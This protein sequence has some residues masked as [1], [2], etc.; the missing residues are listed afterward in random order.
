MSNLPL[1]R[2]D[3][4]DERQLRFVDHLCTLI[5]ENL[6]QPEHEEDEEGEIVLGKDG[7][8]K[9]KPRLSMSKMRVE[10]A[11]RAGYNSSEAYAATESFRLL[12]QEKIQQAITNWW[13]THKVPYA[14]A[15]MFRMGNIIMSTGSKDAD[16]IKA[17]ETFM[18]RDKEMAKKAGKLDVQHSNVP[19]SREARM[20]ELTALM[21]FIGVKQQNVVEAAFTE[22]LPAPVAAEVPVYDHHPDQPGRAVAQTIEDYNKFAKAKRGAARP[23][24][25]QRPDRKPRGR[26][27]LPAN[28]M[29][30]GYHHSR[31]L[32]AKALNK[33]CEDI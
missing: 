25:P 26:R 8:P 32:R 20:A 7:R 15:G 31:K 16:A 12:Q 13:A 30:P 33:L 2:G 21:Q 1:R 23:L 11:M 24:K 14:L 27:P 17:T 28:E 19:M 18:D 10:A 9:G 4:P 6:V 22:V 5:E 3:E 29:A